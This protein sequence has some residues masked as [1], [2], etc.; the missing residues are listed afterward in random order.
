MAA[1]PDEKKDYVKD[2]EKIYSSY[3]EIIDIAKNTMGDF[4]CFFT[5]VTLKQRPSV[6]FLK[7]H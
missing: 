2:V 5:I 7:P 3:A 4:R 1:D 6:N